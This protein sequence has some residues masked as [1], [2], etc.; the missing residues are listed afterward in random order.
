[1]TLRAKAY[2]LP[3][4]L[5]YPG[6][7]EKELK[8][9]LP[10]LP[11]KAAD[12]YEPFVGGGAVYLAM[13]AEHY[14]INDKSSDLMKLYEKV[15]TEDPDFF[16]NLRAMDQ[17]WRFLGHLAEAH[18]NELIELYRSYC[19]LPH[20][21]SR[22]TI[23]SAYLDRLTAYTDDLAFLTLARPSWLTCQTFLEELTISFENKFARMKKLEETKGALSEKDLFCNLEVCLKNSFYMYMRRRCNH[24]KENPISD[25]EQTALYFFIREYCYSS[26]FRYNSNQEFNVP[27]GGISYNR[28]TLEKKIEALTNPELLSQLKRTALSTCDFADFFRQRPPKPEDFIFLDP[29]YDTTFSSY[30]G[31]AFGK[32][33]QKRLADYLIR[34][35]PAYFMLII[36][37][38]EFI[39]DLY[40]EET[41]TAS[42]RPLFVYKFSKQYFVSF[43]DRNDKKAE[44]LMITNYPVSLDLS[45]NVSPEPG[46]RLD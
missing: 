38:T 3:P 1:M 8:Y 2:R 17:C 16:E 25:G 7:K 5:K 4:L 12:Y 11:P 33:D 13:E 36:K 23:L 34:Q 6:G 35:C 19:R 37:N 43:K 15:R 26:M 21:E 42:G 27:Y 22:S 45:L 24:K 10:A 44:H 30:D 31:N 40:P 29:P 18:K 20:T 46:K 9:I 41:E 39:T 32:E 14:F 28:K